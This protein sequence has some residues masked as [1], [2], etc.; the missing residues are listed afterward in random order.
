M[1]I[2]EA[3]KAQNSKNEKA[4]IGFFFSMTPLALHPQEYQLRKS[5]KFKASFQRYVR[6]RSAGKLKML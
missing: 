4:E 1:K 2:Y 5:K 6:S 3:Y